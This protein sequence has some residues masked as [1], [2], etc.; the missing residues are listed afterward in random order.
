M[1][2]DATLWHKFWMGYTPP[3]REAT[4][5]SRSHLWRGYSKHMWL[6]RFN[7]WRVEGCL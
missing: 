4:C 6:L 3:Y 2:E 7:I 5:V 1:A